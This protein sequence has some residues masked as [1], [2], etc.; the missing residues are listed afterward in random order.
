MHCGCLCALKIDSRI[1]CDLFYE[2]KTDMC[3]FLFT[4][5]IIIDVLKAYFGIHAILSAAFAQIRIRV[6]FF[7]L[8]FSTTCRDHSWIIACNCGHMF[9][10]GVR[11]PGV[12][13]E[14]QFELC[15][16]CIACI[17]AFGNQK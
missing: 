12:A 8:F 4:T 5:S 17:Q 3:K 13:E 1:Q 7:R 2:M 9:H 15:V 11:V 6:L 16:E 14:F 10:R